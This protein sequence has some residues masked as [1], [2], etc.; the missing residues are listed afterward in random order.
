MQY[1]FNNDEKKMLNIII[2]SFSDTHFY[3]VDP[4]KMTNED[5]ENYMG[6]ENKRVI[7]AFKSLYSMF[8]GYNN[9]KSFKEN[10]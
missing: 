2:D 5:W 4:L 9:Y 7:N 3:A 10:K 1:K 6:W 8:G